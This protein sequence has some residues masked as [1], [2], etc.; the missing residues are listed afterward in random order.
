MATAKRART[1]KK[2]GEAKAEKPSKTATAIT[3]LMTQP[4]DVQDAIRQRAYELFQRRGGQH[5]TDL[6][7]WVRAEREIL[8]ELRG[9]IA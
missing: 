4:V 7:D 3:E 8:L 9:R 2:N 1:T 5:G 6:E